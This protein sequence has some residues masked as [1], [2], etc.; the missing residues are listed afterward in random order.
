MKRGDIVIVDFPY[1]DRT[2]SKKR[3]SLVVQAD[4]LN[5]SRDDTILAIITA[6]SCGRKAVELPID[7][8]Q[9]P[10]SGLKFQSFLQCDTH[11]TLDQS[12]IL[13]VIGSLSPQAMLEVGDRLKAALGLP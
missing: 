9:E 7:P 12:L 5:Q 1:S 6:A 11:V 13:N 3:P 10:G 2:G 4:S 8:S